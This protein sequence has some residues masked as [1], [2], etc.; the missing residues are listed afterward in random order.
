MRQSSGLQIGGDTI[1][2]EGDPGRSLPVR[3]G[4]TPLT[5]WMPRAVQCPL[6]VGALYPGPGRGTAAIW[7]DRRPGRDNSKKRD[8]PE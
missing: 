1:A 3:P 2:G 5:R 6:A 8:G 7:E 4:M